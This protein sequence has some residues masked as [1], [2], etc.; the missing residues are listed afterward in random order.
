[1]DDKDVSIL[2][3]IKRIVNRYSIEK[4]EN[5]LN[6]DPMHDAEVLKPTPLDKY[7][8]YTQQLKFIAS[9]QGK[10]NDFEETVFYNLEE[11]YCEVFNITKHS[12]FKRNKDNI[13][14]FYTNRNS[15]ECAIKYFKTRHD[16]KQ[17]LD[18]LG[19]PIENGIKKIKLKGQKITQIQKDETEIQG[20]HLQRIEG[21]S[22]P[23]SAIP[24]KH[25]YYDGELD[26][27]D[28]QSLYE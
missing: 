9:L 1:M 17:T 6:Y 25:M 2:A 23:L 20:R 19:T 26:M 10:L 12:D 18:D 8:L 11:L 3:E 7:R 27:E 22:Q 13:L 14:K 24:L 5:I 28:A 16:Y 21:L 4:H 15:R